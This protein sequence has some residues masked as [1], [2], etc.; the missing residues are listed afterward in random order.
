MSDPA[1]T[2]QTADPAARLIARWTW[3]SFYGLLFL[4]VAFAAATLPPLLE[5]RGDGATMPAALTVAWLVALLTLSLVALGLLSAGR[6]DFLMRD[7]AERRRN[8]EREQKASEERLRTVIDS[9]ADA[10]IVITPEGLVESANAA[11]E[12]LFGYRPDELIGRNISLLMPEP[13][14]GR[15]DGYL[16]AYRAGGERKVIGFRR[17]LTAQRKDGTLFPIE[18]AVSESGGN[19]ETRYVG[20]IRDISMAL[21]ARDELARMQNFIQ[22]T[23]DSLTASICV[24][25]HDGIIVHANAPWRQHAL[26]SGLYDEHGGLGSDYLAV[27][28]AVRGGPGHEGHLVARA[29]RRVLDGQDDDFFAEYPCHTAGHQCWMMLSATSFVAD[30]ER[31]VVVAHEDITELRGSQ[32]ELARKIEELHTTLE[33]MRQGITMVDRDLNV[34]IANRKYF[35]LMQLPPEFYGSKL[36]M[37]EMIRYQALRGDYGPGDPEEQVRLRTQV[38]DQS[39]MRRA[40][41]TFADGS[42]VEI[43][44]STLPHGRGAVATYNDITQRKRTENELRRAKEAADAAS[45]AK[46]AFLATMSH[47]IRTPMYG[48]LGMAELLEA[49]P[50]AAEQRK[51]VK[52]VRDSGN[53]LLAII[54]DILDLSRIEAGKLHIDAEPMSLRATVQAVQDILAPA[55]AKKG[56][57]FYANISSVVPDGLVGDAVRLRQVLF[58]LLGNAV[59]FTDATAAGGRA[60]RVT[61]RVMLESADVVSPCIVRFI[62]EDN[63]IGMS[64]EVLARLFQPFSQ[65]DSATT[66]RYGGSGLGLSICGRLV[67]MMGGEVDV[68]SHPGEGTIFTVRLPFLVATAGEGEP[69]AAS[70]EPTFSATAP[71]LAAGEVRLLVAEDNEI[72]QDLIRRQLGSLGYAV[73][74]VANGREALEQLPQADYALLLT[75]CQMPEMDGYALARAVREGEAARGG[76]RRLPIIAFTANILARDIQRCH[77]A[78]MDDVVGKPIVLEQLGRTL[79]RWVAAVPAPLPPA[80]GAAPAAAAEARTVKLERLD[81]LIGPNQQAQARILEKFLAGARLLLDEIGAAAQQGDAAALGALGHKL[82]SSARAIGA[83]ALADACAALEAAGKGADA[84]AG[85]EHAAAAAGHFAAASTEIEAYLAEPR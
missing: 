27:S 75:D 19:S 40:E 46:S 33:T 77:D 11:T 64:E 28:E 62:V 82:K 80:A 65:A 35:Q 52:A 36:T 13:H 84:A 50:L 32:H 60:G 71:A 30:G 73:D 8:A 68:T 61:L 10:I 29:L 70:P 37:Q 58:N 59:K 24:L 17:E 81:A 21:Q 25:D 53:A 15:H 2:P 74:M 31:R 44:W 7:E 34:V 22:C 16:A 45:E 67:N 42:V 5:L 55:A 47:E 48:I 3:G 69:L 4:C 85:A 54:N 18:L 49:T 9:T 38:F 14:R 57:T 83:D 79:A 39:A 56:L 12:G 66:R 72:N 26:A 78:G 51:M 76:G 41:R 63:G 43:F 6:V 20:I 23:L 1:E